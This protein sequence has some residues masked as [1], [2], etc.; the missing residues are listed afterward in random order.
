SENRNDRDNDEKFNQGEAALSRLAHRL[1]GH[2]FLLSIKMRRGYPLRGALPLLMTGLLPETAGRAARPRFALPASPDT[3]AA[4][5]VAAGGHVRRRRAEAA[6]RRAKTGA[7]ALRPRMRR[8]ELLRRLALLRRHNAERPVIGLLAAALED[9]P[10][11]F[12]VT[13][14]P[15]R[16]ELLPHTLSDVRHRRRD[17][18]LLICRQVQVADQFYRQARLGEQSDIL[19]QARQSLLLL[20]GENGS[21]LLI[22]RSVQRAHLLESSAHRLPVR[23]RAAGLSV[24]GATRPAGATHRTRGH[25]RAPLL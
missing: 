10:H 20:G 1:R 9:V 15:R 3:T 4:L 25:Q 2:R 21:E 11:S 16:V 19:H 22:R 18:L 7:A 5:D 12:A 6:R 8:D 23:R 17:L 13:V 24:R 14:L